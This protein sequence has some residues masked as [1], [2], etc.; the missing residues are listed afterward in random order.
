MFS[1]KWLIPLIRRCVISEVAA[2]G[3]GLLNQIPDVS[4]V[5]NMSSPPLRGFIWNV[6]TWFDREDSKVKKVDAALHVIN[7]T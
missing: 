5:G 3:H 7:N 4:E 1:V 2:G 6:K